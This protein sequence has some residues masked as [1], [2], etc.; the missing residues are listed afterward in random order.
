MDVQVSKGYAYVAAEWIGGLHVI[1]VHDPANPQ[2]MSEYIPEQP[3]CNGLA[4]WKN[5]I[6]VENLVYLACN[7]YGL[8]IV[9]VSDPANPQEL[10]GLNLKTALTDIAIADGFALPHRSRAGNLCCR[11][12]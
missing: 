9:D 8:R 3:G 1:D 11:H 2:V 10:S 7:P 4:L 6:Y 5:R 12:P